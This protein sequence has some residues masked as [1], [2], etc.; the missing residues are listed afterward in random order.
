MCV[1]SAVWYVGSEE[2]SVACL[3]YEVV[4]V[5]ICCICSVVL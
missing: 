4:R 2:F 3:V 1:V 5:G